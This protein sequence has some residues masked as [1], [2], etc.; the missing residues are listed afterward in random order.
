MRIGINLL[1]LT[2]GEIG[3]MEQYSRSLINAIASRENQK[4]YLFLNEHVAHSFAP[5]PRVH[6][7]VLRDDGD[8]VRQIH[9]A[10]SRHAIQIWF[11][12]LLIME[13]HDMNIPTVVTIP[14][15]QHIYYPQ[16]FSH[17]VL[18]WRQEHFPYTV[19]HADAIITLSSH[20]KQTIIQAYQADPRRVHPIWL[21]ASQYFDQ[22]LLPEQVEAILNKYQLNAG[23]AFLPG[24]TW[25]HKNHLV[26]LQAAAYLKQTFGVTIQLVFTGNQDQ[27]M[28]VLEQFIATHNLT[29]QVRFLGYIPQEDLPYIYQAAQFLIFPSL[30]EGFGIPLVEAMKTSTPILCSNATSIPEVAGEAALYFHPHDHVDLAHKILQMQDDTIRLDLIEKGQARGTLFSWAR[31]SEATL[32]VFRQVLQKQATS[33]NKASRTKKSATRLI[34]KRRKKRVRR[35]ARPLRKKIYRRKRSN[36]AASRRLKHLKRPKRIQR[37]KRFKRLK[38]RSKR[39]SH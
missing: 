7:I 14:D 26:V 3:G 10:V 12:P 15:V 31:T 34:R 37:F 22:A 6:P 2:P 21:D 32:D 8:V 4:I 23:F 29:E 17:D 27:Q 36:R 1:K 28:P 19:K 25:P 24:N 11:C 18:N 16:F 20:A 38:P 13:P 30:Y 5:Q 35:R 39:K 33:K 9:R